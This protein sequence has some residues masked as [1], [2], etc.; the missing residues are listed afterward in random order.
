MTDSNQNILGK[1]LT[2]WRLRLYTVIFEADTRAGRL[3]DQWLIA[4]ILTSIVVVVVDS[5]QSIDSTHHSIFLWLEWLFTLAFTVEYVARLVCV[6][7]PLRY[8]L[9]FYGVIDLLALLPT[10]VALLVPEVQALIDVRVLRLLRVFRIFKLTAY[11]AEYQ[12]LGHALNASRRKILV[13]LS[14]VLMIV[15][16]MGTLMYVVEGPNNGFTNIPTSVYWAITTMTTVGFGDITP[17][18]D[19]GRLISSAMMLLG[20][21]TL[22]VPTGIVTAEMTARRISTAPTTR[23]CQECLTEGHLAQASFCFHCGAQLP[24]Y[25]NDAPE[26]SAQD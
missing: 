14:A 21:G 19:L 9:S 17:K 2:G 5:V 12:S 8:A 24:S 4:L 20:W 18:T 15:L 1:P 6:R 16:V 22:A 3:F 11:V 7:H 23:T 25:I 10:Y 26:R 13:F